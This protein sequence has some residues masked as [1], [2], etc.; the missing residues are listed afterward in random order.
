MTVALRLVLFVAVAVL[1]GWI[2]T[3]RAAPIV[4]PV[5]SYICRAPD[6]RCSHEWDH[7]RIV[8]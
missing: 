3:G 1:A 5:D 8:E 4:Q 7:W 6:A 2:I